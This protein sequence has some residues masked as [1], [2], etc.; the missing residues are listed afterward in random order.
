MGTFMTNARAAK[1][2]RLHG[3]A[4]AAQKAGDTRR[5]EERFQR[6]LELYTQAYD[7]GNRRKN[8]MMAYGNILLRYGYFDKAR[9]I[10]KEAAQLPGMTPKE[11]CQLRINYSVCLWKLGDL[12]AAL[13]TIRKAYASM[14]STV[15]Y[16][17]M[18]T[19][20]IQKAQQTG[21]YAEAGAFAKEALE[22]DEEDASL[23]DN[24]GQ[25]L[26]FSSLGDDRPQE[27]AA[28]IAEAEKAFRK[29]LTFKKD[30][31]TTLYFLALICCRTG[32]V[33]EASAFM[34]T[35]RACSYTAICQIQ[36]KQIRE[37]EE[38]IASCGGN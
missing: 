32:R 35:L 15:I 38:E 34:R 13:D 24:Y 4:L 29:A 27:Q 9:D 6:A 8:I 7:G 17:T 33:Q 10:L 2:Y 25:F 20:L 28:G 18:G 1:A 36:E 30:Q 11:I 22:Y 37:L 21:D 23:Q 26:Y 12:D 16:S 19:Y 3:S 14:H 5:A 31:V